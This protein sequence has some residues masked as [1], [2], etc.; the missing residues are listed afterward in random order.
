LLFYN[1]LL[2]ENAACHLALGRAYPITLQGGSAMSTSQFAAAGGNNSLLHVDFMIGCG[3]M[4]V[5]G[6]LENGSTEPIIR[7][8]EWAFNT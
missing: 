7:S 8:G 1:G 2:D 5:D 4:N 3:E 6:L